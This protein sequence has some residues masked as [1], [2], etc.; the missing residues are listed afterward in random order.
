MIVFVASLVVVIGLVT[1]IFDMTM[2]GSKYAVWA[3]WGLVL[4]V[5]GLLVIRIFG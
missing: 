4:C 5:I 3:P 1:A 2:N